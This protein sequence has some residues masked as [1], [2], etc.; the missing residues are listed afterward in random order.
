MTMKQGLQITS[1]TLNTQAELDTN[2]VE[3]AK[4]A[5]KTAR[6]P[7]NSNKTKTF[8]RLADKSTAQIS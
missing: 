3:E 1:K 5:P 8:H 6:K 2:V 4:T 7:I